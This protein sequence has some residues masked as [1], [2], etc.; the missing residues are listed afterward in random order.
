MLGGIMRL[1]EKFAAALFLLK[2][3][4]GRIKVS[5]LVPLCNFFVF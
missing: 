5:R 4:F 2:R 1:A 3:G